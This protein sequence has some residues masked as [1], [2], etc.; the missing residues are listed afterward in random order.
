MH[1]LWAWPLQT[2]WLRLC[3]C[4]SSTVGKSSFKLNLTQSE[5]SDSLTA[6]PPPW[7]QKFLQ[8]HR[9]F[10]SQLL[11][12]WFTSQH[13]VPSTAPPISTETPVTDQP[14]KP[15]TLLTDLTISPTH[16]CWNLHVTDPPIN[17]CILTADPPVNS[18]PP[19]TLPTHPSTMETLCRR[20][21]LRCCEWLFR[22]PFS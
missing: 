19:Y 22:Y 13:W 10:L 17:T 1:A 15:E 5:K 16:Q 21:S 20:G 6:N 4:N 2:W 7:M 14:I 11:H 12:E 3:P 18:E 9:H 8:Y